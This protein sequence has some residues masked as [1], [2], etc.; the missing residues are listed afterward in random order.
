MA[1]IR[2]LLREPLLHFLLLGSLLFGW[3]SWHDGGAGGGRIVVPRAVVEHLASGFESTWHR[4][5]SDE[6]LRGLVDDHVR[7]QVA[8]R[9][10]MAM[11]LDRDDIVIQRRL[12]QKLEFVQADDAQ[13]PPTEAELRAWL[14]QH[15]ETFRREPQLSFRQVFLRPDPHR[16]N[17]KADADRL[18]ARLRT[19][20]PDAVIKDLGDASMLPN[21]QPLAALREAER[22]FGAG[23][24][25]ELM[26]LEPGKWSGPVESSYGLHLVFV[27]ERIDAAAADLAAVRPQVERELLAEQRKAQLDKL[28][29][30]LM[31]KYAVRV[32]MPPP[33]PL[34]AANE[35]RTAP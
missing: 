10:A 29:A 33:R 35:T 8:A 5:P 21:D 14:A 20:G 18:L 22:S 2:R 16:D 1:L 19:A 25:D 13:A 24:A 4:A 11:G 12:R 17:L 31:A 15:A 3:W 30:Q 34:A 28:Y 7:Q 6:E 9:E 23:F 26:K 32:E 27:R